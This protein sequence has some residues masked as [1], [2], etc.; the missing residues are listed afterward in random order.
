LSRDITPLV[1]HLQECIESISERYFKLV[2][3]VGSFGS[4][5]TSLLQEYYSR[6]PESSVYINLNHALTKRL[7]DVPKYQRPMISG[8]YVS[9]I[10]ETF[11][12]QILLVDNIEA[13]FDPELSIDALKLLQKSSRSKIL[14]VSWPGVYKEEEISYAEPGYRDYKSYSIKDLI[15]I[16]MNREKNR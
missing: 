16:D 9:E 4:G 1:G 15:I 13:L 10:F 12:N 5:K 7:L 14:V 8:K 3:V 2:I 6:A 11:G